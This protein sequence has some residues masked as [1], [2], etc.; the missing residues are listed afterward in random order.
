MGGYDEMNEDMAEKWHQEKKKK[1]KR[2]P[3]KELLEIFHNME[4]AK[5]E[6]LEMNPNFERRI[7]IYQDVKKK[8]VAPYAKLY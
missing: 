5:H 1:K 4:S 8:M 2:L 6:I 3:L 7:A